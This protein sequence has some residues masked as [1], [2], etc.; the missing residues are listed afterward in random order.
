MSAPLTPAETYLTLGLTI[1]LL[2][3]IT[4]L[5]LAMIVRLRKRGLL[6]QG[7]A[8]VIFLPGRRSRVFMLVSALG[9]LFILG[10][11]V[12]ALESLGWLST[13]V[14]NVLVSIVYIGGA[15]CMIL[16]ITVGLRPTPLSDD[17]RAEAVRSSRE[18]MMLAFAPVEARQPPGPSG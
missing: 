13:I 14:L 8:Q 3:L 4:G 5:F 12:Q 18:F 2:G 7:L 6:D 11:L 17:Q 16:L 9:V 1:G 10:G 15:L